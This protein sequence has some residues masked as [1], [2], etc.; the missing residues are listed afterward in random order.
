VKTFICD[1]TRANDLYQKIS[2][3][4]MRKRK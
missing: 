1:T 4:E 2:E 3:E